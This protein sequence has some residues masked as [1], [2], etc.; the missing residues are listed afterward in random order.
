MAEDESKD[1]TEDKPETGK[2]PVSEAARAR[3]KSTRTAAEKPARDTGRQAANSDEKSAAEG[4]GTTASD[5]KDGAESGDTP[6]D[7]G[8]ALPRSSWALGAVFG[9]VILVVILL[10]WPQGRGFIAGLFGGSEPAPSAALVERLDALDSRLTA[11]GQ[12]LAAIKADPPGAEAAAEA[13]AALDQRITQL[14]GRPDGQ[15]L[16]AKV[17]ALENRVT[18]LAETVSGL[19][20]RIGKTEAGD[21]SSTLAVMALAG[22]LRTGGPFAGLAARVRAEADGDD[23]LGSALKSLEPYAG[24]GVPTVAALTGRVETIGVPI[25]G[26]KPEKPA[27]AQEDAGSAQ[28][29]GFWDKVKANLLKLGRVRKTPEKPDVPDIAVTVRAAT[30][31]ALLRGDLDAAQ[32]AAKDLTGPKASAWRDDLAARITANELATRLDRLAA[33]RLAGGPAQP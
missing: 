27:P 16:T 23:A 5:T 18:Q 29:T 7:P 25:A 11:L 28:P 17:E 30:A 22:A 32:E 9:A 31:E 33:E 21:T 24:K 4:S 6:S 12:D 13:R 10:A 20:T 3:T 15:G 26:P 19:E 14:E 1:K 2:T 8:F